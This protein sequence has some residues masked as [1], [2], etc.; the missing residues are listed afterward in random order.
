MLGEEGQ[1]HFVIWPLR[2]KLMFINFLEN[3]LVDV[4]ES[5]AVVLRPLDLI[6][7][8]LVCGLTERVG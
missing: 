7:L 5:L 2:L 3:I 8:L 1:F 4:C 6:I